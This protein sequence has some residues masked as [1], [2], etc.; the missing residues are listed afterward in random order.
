MI[1]ILTLFQSEKAIFMRERSAGT[2]R[3]SAYYIAKNL[4]ELPVQIFLP[5]VFGSII[6]WMIGLNTEP[7][8]FFTFLLLLVTTVLAAQSLG[9][10][11]SAA[12]PSMQIANAVGPIVM[13]LFLLFGGFYL[14]S[15]DIWPGFYWIK[16]ISFL[17]YGYR[18]IAANEYAGLV[19]ECNTGIAR[20]VRT[21]DEVL[22]QLDFADV[23]K[24]ADFGVLVALVVGYRFLAY[25]ALLY[26][27]KPKSKI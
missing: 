19:F 8:R 3:V 7:G 23:N 17:N 2:Y 26:L 1:A 22:E 20:C 15:A 6:Y 24:W 21:G 14:N 4:S 11:I 25:L 18:A 10:V 12:A 13:I 9:Q 27:A 5:I 16:Y